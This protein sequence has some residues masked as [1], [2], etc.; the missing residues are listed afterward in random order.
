M[1][2]DE[3]SSTIPIAPFSYAPI[4]GDLIDRLTVQAEEIALLR[5]AFKDERRT[6]VHL[7]CKVS[8]LEDLNRQLA[9]EID[10]LNDE[11]TER[12]QAISTSQR[13][14]E[15]ALRLLAGREDRILDWAS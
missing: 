13:N 6:I 8:M 2:L 11:I 4:V 7:E 14:V 10:E 1:R 5:K 15:T 9:E 3:D 12:D